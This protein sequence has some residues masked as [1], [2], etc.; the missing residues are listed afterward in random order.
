MSKPTGLKYDQGKPRMELISSIALIE[1]A[2]VYNAGAKKYSDHNWRGGMKWS[3]L[4]GAA[5]RHLVAYIG[6]ESKDPE[7]GLSH[8]AHVATCM[9]F[10]LEYEVTHKELDDRFVEIKSAT[11]LGD[12]SGFVTKNHPKFC[13]HLNQGAF[14]ITT[15]PPTMETRCINCNTVLGYTKSVS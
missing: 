3:R 5:M 11:L 2:K 1:I 8:L 10:L 4:L 7:S 13:N 15:N 6:G 12:P 14:L 9:T